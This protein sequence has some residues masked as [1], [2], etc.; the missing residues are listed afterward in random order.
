[1]PK[2]GFKSFTVTD[3]VYN[4]YFQTYKKC[5]TD[6]KM[7]GVRSFTGYIQY[8]MK[9]SL[10]E[11]AIFTKYQ[12]IFTKISVDSERIIL[13]DFQLDRIIELSNDKGLLFCKFC[14]RDNCKHVGFS[15][16]FPEIYSV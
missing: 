15:W 1:M 12:Q 11:N 6:L 4:T 2:A 3:L 14:E 8:L 13:K 7:K 9:R 5:K 10:K 16:S